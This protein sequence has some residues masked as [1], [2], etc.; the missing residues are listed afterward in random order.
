MIRRLALIIAL[1]VALP[2]AA[3][4]YGWKDSD[5]RTHYSDQPPP[6]G[7]VQILQAPREHRA[8]LPTASTEPIGAEQNQA[9]QQDQPG[10]G[11]R[12]KSIAERE[13]EF[14]QRR[15]AA[16]ELQAKAEQDAVRE[17]ERQRFCEQARNQLGGLD[18]GQRITRF[19]AAGEREY[20]DDA[21]RAEEA[22][23]L[24]AQLEEHCR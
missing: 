19:N 9:G 10:D 13:L 4:I 17:A 21:A 24:R 20:L 7:A 6:A 3:E 18:S 16:A 23:R 2:A 22:A 1:L 12:A 8:G 14:R 11:A 5:G 15:A